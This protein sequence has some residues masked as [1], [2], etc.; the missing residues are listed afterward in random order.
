MRNGKC[1]ACELYTKY[2]DKYTCA[3]DVC[4]KN[5]KLK[6]DGTCKPAAT[7]CEND[8]NRVEKCSTLTKCFNPSTFQYDNSE[9]KSQGEA[10]ARWSDGNKNEITGC[11]LSEYCGTGGF[12][13]GVN[14]NF[15]CP[16]GKEK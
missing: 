10:C 9:C 11:I 1:K 14:T 15:K 3:A 6:M 8:D 4:D 13:K 7:D 2:V 5:W 16:N 12:F